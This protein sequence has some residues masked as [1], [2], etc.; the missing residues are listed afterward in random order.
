MSSQK[1]SNQQFFNLVQ[2]LALKS[3]KVRYKNSIL[4]FMWSL[5]TPL[6]YLG[7]FT[8]VF[9]NVFPDIENYPLYALTGLIFWNFFS[10]STQQL[11]MSIVEGSGVLKSI[12][13]PPVSYP[14]GFLVAQLINLL[15][16]FIPFAILMVVFGFKPSLALLLF[17]VALVLLVM[18][19][20]GA[21]L[22]ISSLNVYFRDV[23]L[24]WQAITPALFY[25]TPV[26]YSTR[27]IPEQF[28]WLLNFNPMY[29]YINFFRDILY[30]GEFPSM[31]QWIVT[32][33]IS[34]TSLLIG[35]FVFRRLE[36]GFVSNY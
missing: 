30:Y 15:L 4:G 26:A 34:V 10:S 22:L 12:N 29:H 3:L 33:L 18:F 28:A 35:V 9:S 27:L 5:I 1:L 25:A 31:L 21:G 2:A 36:P 24:L 6:M 11:S 13:I 23:G 20:L 16:T 19:T 17:P 7:I 32:V 14:V 8:F